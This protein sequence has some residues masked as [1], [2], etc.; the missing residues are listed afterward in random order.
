MSNELKISEIY[1]Q[2]LNFLIGSG[3]SHGLFPTLALKIKNEENK[4]HTI[5]TLA[6]HFEVTKND[7]NKTALFMHYYKSCIEPVMEFN[8]AGIATNPNKKKVIENYQNFIT[9]VLAILDK[10]NS[11]QRCNIFTTNYDGCFQFSAEEILKNGAED[12]VVNDGGRGFL[13]KF[14]QARNFNSYLTHSGVFDKYVSEVRQIN[15]IHVHGCV[16]W[17]NANENITINYEPKL[18]NLKI[19]STGYAKIADFSNLINDETKTIADLSNIDFTPEESKSF[20][21]KYNKLPI[22]NPTKWKFHETVFEEHYYQM[23]RQLSYELERQ[24]TVLLTFGF[25]F[26]DEHILNIVKRSLSNPK[27]QLFISCF[28]V[29]ELA[30][31]K[32]KFEK[33]KNVSYLTLDTELLNFTNFNEKIFCLKKKETSGTP[34]TP[35]ASA[36]VESAL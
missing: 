15:L 20:W 27:L 33:F 31:M 35:D 23:L 7:S 9:T 24:N 26:A 21:D 34:T 10:R 4:P 18:E 19:E 6:R 2:N 17:Q 14:L 22:V 36:P 11:L 12:F 16:Y 8:L 3:A 32:S 13:N 1:N 28:D 5:E 25:S 30:L 29:A